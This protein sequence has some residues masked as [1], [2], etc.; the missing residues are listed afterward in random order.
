MNRI[1]TLMALALAA[2][3]ATARPAAASTRMPDDAGRT[4]LLAT[5]NSW[6]R[7]DRILVTTPDPH[8]VRLPGWFDSVESDSVLRVRFSRSSEPVPL[9]L[10][11]IGTLSERVGS[12]GHARAGALAGLAVGLFV[13]SFLEVA[14]EDDPDGFIHGPNRAYIPLGVV[15]GL[16]VGTTI[17][18]ATR[19]DVWR[20]AA[21]FEEP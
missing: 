5:A 17:G 19:T 6:D 13:G 11:Q 8:H 20:E 16:F 9:R 7:G 15:A 12:K 2:A 21:R 18:T 4:L 3:T 14:I 1:P 10:S